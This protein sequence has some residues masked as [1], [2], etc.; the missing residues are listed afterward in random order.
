[1]NPLLAGIAAGVKLRKRGEDQQSAPSSLGG[2]TF[3]PAARRLSKRYD[4]GVL[5]NSTD[6]RKAVEQMASKRMK[7]LQWEKLNKTRTDKTIWEQ[8]GTPETEMVAELQKR[9][10]FSEMEDEFKAREIAQDAMCQYHGMSWRRRLTS[11]VTQPRR[12]R[13]N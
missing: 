10:I 6:G 9:N 13:K 11:S 3:A 5:S 4:V 8:P 12:R 7:Q 1:M 2:G